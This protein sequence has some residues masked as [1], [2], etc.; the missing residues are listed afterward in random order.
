MPL[1]SMCLCKKTKWLYEVNCGLLHSSSLRSLE[2]KPSW[3][4]QPRVQPELGI[5][6]LEYILHFPTLYMQS[7]V[8]GKSLVVFLILH[9]PP[10]VMEVGVLWDGCIPQSALWRLCG[11]IAGNG[12]FYGS[13]PWAATPSPCCEPQVPRWT[14]HGAVAWKWRHQDRL[15]GSEG[16]G[17]WLR[18]EQAVSMPDSLFFAGKLGI[19]IASSR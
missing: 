3:L 15:A 1:K 18:R 7:V 14:L 13:G 6:F 17:V 2:K 4:I 9:R 12:G 11:Q 5:A 16:E 8:W 19:L 10:M